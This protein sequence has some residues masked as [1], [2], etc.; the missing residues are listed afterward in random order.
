MSKQ[1][2]VQ[3]MVDAPIEKVWDAY[4][5]PKHIV[6]WNHASDDW[7]CPRAVNDLTVGGRFES[8]MESKDGEEGF[9]FAGTY[10]KVVPK[11]TIAYTMDGPDK[12]KATVAFEDVFESAEVTVRFDPEDENP[13]AMQKAG[14]QAILDNFKEYAE[15]LK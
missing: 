10:T 6:K 11:K 3:V 13:I 8:R 12:R 7:K 15:H 2:T 9:D 5:N 4:T 1:I 14:W